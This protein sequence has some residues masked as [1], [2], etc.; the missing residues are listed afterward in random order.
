M[1]RAALVIL[2]A[3]LIAL[4]SGCASPGRGY[5]RPY[6]PGPSG[7]K[8][9]D[10]PLADEMSARYAMRTHGVRFVSGRPAVRLFHWRDLRILSSYME[11]YRKPGV[12]GPSNW[13]RIADKQDALG[14]VDI[15][16]EAPN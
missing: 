15:P 7:E 6:R 1:K 2:L 3:P 11:L 12:T 13:Y 4:C 10:L 5:M 8:P 9:V 16:A 14:R